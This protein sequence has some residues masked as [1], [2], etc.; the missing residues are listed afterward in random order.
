MNKRANKDMLYTL[1]N[2]LWR[3]VAGPALLLSI[4]IFL[5]A[6]EQGYWYTFTSIAALSVLQIL[7]FQR[8]ILQFTAH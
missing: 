2:Q 8:F 6:V 4:P 7:G 5:T 1:L 3:V